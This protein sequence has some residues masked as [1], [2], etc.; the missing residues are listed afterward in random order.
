MDNVKYQELLSYLQNLTPQS[1]EYEKWVNQFHEKLNHVYKEER[2]VVP[3]SEI[4]WIMSIFYDDPTKAHQS[5]D[6][7]YNQISKRYIWQNMRSNIKEY[8]KTCFQCQQRES[9]K[10]NN[11]KK[12]ILPT[13]IFE[14][15]GIDIVRPLPITREGNRY[16][17]VAMDYFS[18]WPEARPLKMANADT[19]ATFIYVYI[20]CRFGP[21]RILQ[22]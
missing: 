2:R 16:I 5:F 17:V 11:Q 18:R 21:P 3:Q 10:Q 12:T 9:M 22:S 20:I 7:M 4:K 13:D 8:A 6:T 15:W 14:R 19:V 1:E